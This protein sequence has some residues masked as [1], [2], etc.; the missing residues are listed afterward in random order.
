MNI[1]VYADGGSRG[2]PGDA[3]AGAI[4]KDSQG[5]T[6]ATVSAYLGVRTNNFAEYEAII[7]MCEMLIK[8]LSKKERSG[9]VININMD[10]ELVV[11]QMKGIYKVK[12]SVLRIQYARLTAL[13]FSFGKVSFK[14]VPRTQNKIA[15]CLANEAMNRG[16]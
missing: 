6:L 16:E 5:K 8:I 14:H 12:N 1:T 9:A 4:A 15:D 10:S 2:N 7:L 11:K 3:G 13:I